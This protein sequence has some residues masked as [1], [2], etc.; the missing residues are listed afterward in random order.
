MAFPNARRILR[1]EISLSLFKLLAMQAGLSRPY[2]RGIC[3]TLIAPFVHHGE[4]AL[5][6]RCHGRRYM[7]F[8]RMSD[9]SSDVF[10]V[11][12][13]ATADDVYRLDPHFHPDL[14]VDGGGN[15]GLFAMLAAALYPSAKIVVCEPAPRSLKQI[16][17]HL[18]LNQVRAEVLPICLGGTRRTI[19]FYV[20]E[21]IA[22]SF[23]PEK[24]YQSVM[25]VEVLTLSDVLKGRD[26]ARILIKLDIEGME[27]EVLEAY[28]PKETRPVC[29]V[30]E[31]HGRKI[32]GSRLKEI[33][34]ASGW[35]LV[36]RD[37]SETDSIFEAR[38]PAARIPA[39]GDVTKG[40]SPSALV[41]G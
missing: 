31:L 11:N 30:G 22:S 8:V 38:S 37:S 26:A 25:D 20:R 23:D 40:P 27:L 1:G 29:V 36:F 39:S 41:S 17:K 16:E 24:P 12:E 28:V 4:V 21:A 7:A 33:F 34:D 32:H 5:R 19:P 15:I 2:L 6:Y 10:T 18:R 13:L 14:I 9:M 35:S 3:D